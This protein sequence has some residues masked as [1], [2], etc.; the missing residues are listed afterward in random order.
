MHTK[1]QQLR[2]VSTALVFLAVA[3]AL[4]VCAGW[5]AGTP[6]DTKTTSAGDAVTPEPRTIVPQESVAVSST[7]QLSVIY[8]ERL[9]VAPGAKLTVTV[10]DA[11]GRKV[12][13]SS[14]TTAG[15]QT[16]QVSVPLTV[17]GQ[18]AVTVNVT[19]KAPSGHVLTGSKTF[20]KVPAG[21]TEF[22]IAS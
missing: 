16:Y 20:E 1:R 8:L 17:P 2:L 10:T 14:I 5:P 22:V 21:K 7:L 13:S 4:G 6:T 19:L 11:A 18:Q 15:D 12:G 9:A 3:P